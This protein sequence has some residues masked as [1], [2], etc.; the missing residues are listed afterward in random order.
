MCVG[1]LDAVSLLVVVDD[2]PPV[3]PRAYHS[4]RMEPGDWLAQGPVKSI[5]PCQEARPLRCVF[6]GSVGSL[7][8]TPLFMDPMASGTMAR[9]PLLSGVLLG[10]VCCGLH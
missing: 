10:V 2:G 1:A 9:S 4:R 8:V 3:G 5:S 6:C 7:G